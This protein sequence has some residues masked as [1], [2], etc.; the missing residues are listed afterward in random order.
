MNFDLDSIEFEFNYF[1]LLVLSGN[2]SWKSDFND[3]L[4]Y[5]NLYEAIGKLL[6]NFENETF[7]YLTNKQLLISDLCKHISC[8]LY[9]TKIGFNFLLEDIPNFLDKYKNY[10]HVIKKNLKDIETILNIS[11][12]DIE[13]YYIM[14]HIISNLV[15]EKELTLNIAID[16]LSTNSVFK[17]MLVELNSKIS[18]CNFFNIKDLHN[19]QN[20]DFIICTSN[21]K[22]NEYESKDVLYVN[23]FLTN[24]DLENIKNKISSIIEKRNSEKDFYN[25]YQIDSNLKID[26]IVNILSKKFI[27]INFISNVY[28]ENVLN[29]IKTNFESMI[30]NKNICLLHASA[31][32]GVLKKGFCISI[33]IVKN[34]KTIK[35][36]NHKIKIVIFIVPDLLLTHVE[37]MSNLLSICTQIDNSKDSA[38]I[39]EEIKRKWKVH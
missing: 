23:Q 15:I 8:C 27:D 31:K 7:V 26:S 30:V 24:S 22:I 14:L 32:E 36:D 29:R 38:Y 13:I 16:C 1:C 39:I 5:P 34:N 3:F 20:I 4:I 33:G 10:F 37:P 12:N 6:N 25:F 9:R 18:N 19:L 17:Y 2:I 28:I 11:I 35:V 21:K